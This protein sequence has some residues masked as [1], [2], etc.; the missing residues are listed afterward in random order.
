VLA[1]LTEHLS[2]GLDVLTPADE[3]S[4]DHVHVVLDTKSQIGLVLLG[5]GGKVDIGVGE[6][7]TLLGRDLAIVTGAGADGLV[8]DNLEDVKGEDSI[9]DIDDAS[10]LDDFGDVLVIDVPG[11]WLVFRSG[12]YKIWINLH[13]LLVACGGILVIS[14]DVDLGTGR[15]G[16]VSIA[17]GVTG[18]DLG[19]LGIESDGDLTS[20]LDLLSLAGMVDD[21]LVVLV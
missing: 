1:I 11:L 19:A 16:Q 10:G 15:D 14:G 5:E 8:I 6:V 13:V 2:D 9:V 17:H 4:K 21:G 12:V 18:S 7:D 3:G 20:L